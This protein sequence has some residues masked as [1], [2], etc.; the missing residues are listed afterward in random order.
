MSFSG[1]INPVPFYEPGYVPTRDRN[2]QIE[3]DLTN[4]K[5]IY[6]YLRFNVYKQDAYCKDAAMILYNHIRGI[7]SRN[8]VC[9]PAGSGKTYVWNC[10][11][12]IWPK[13]IFVDS[14]TLTKTGWKGNHTIADFLSSVDFKN[15]NYIIVFDEFDKCVAPQHTTGGENVSATLQGEFL[16]LVEGALMPVKDSRGEH[17]INTARMSFVFCGSF[18]VK[19]GE[20]SEKNSTSGFGFGTTRHVEKQFENELTLQDVIDFGVIPELA[21]RT[22]RIVNVRPL[23]RADYRYL[24]TDHPASPIKK[25]E[26]IYGRKFRLSKKKIDEIAQNAFDSGLGIRNV[27]AQ[28]QKIMDDRIFASFADEDPADPD[29]HAGGGDT[30]AP[31]HKSSKKSKVK[32]EEY[33]F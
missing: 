26:R 20:I 30:A 16:K 19:A 14:S 27:T 22:T 2:V 31:K 4:P 5:K 29:D 18:A 7:T 8:I 6:E 21:S 1:N 32:G 23:T 25:L 15:E 9:G 33:V 24:I 17:M 3:V 13:I 28:L 11:K 12:K 10:L